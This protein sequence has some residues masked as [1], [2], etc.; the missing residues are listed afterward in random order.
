M[1]TYRARRMAAEDAKTLTG[2][3]NADAIQR[4]ERMP[5]VRLSATSGA[6][7]GAINSLLASAEWCADRPLE[8]IGESAFWRAWIPAGVEAL[9]PAKND[10]VSSLLSRKYMDVSLIPMLHD[11]WTKVRGRPDCDVLFGAAITRL[12]AESVDVGGIAKIQSQYMAS[13]VRVATDPAHNNLSFQIT[14]IPKK[15]EGAIGHMAYLPSEH[16]V[17]PDSEVFRLIKA[18]SGY[19]LAFE[20]QFIDYDSAPGATPTRWLQRAQFVDGGVFDNGPIKLGYELGLVHA[21]QQSLHGISVL[22]IYP[23]QMRHHG[24]L[25][26]AWDAR[27]LRHDRASSDNPANVVRGFDVGRIL[28]TNMIPSARQYQLQTAQSLFAADTMTESARILL[29]QTASQREQVLAAQLKQIATTDSGNRQL[30]QMYLDSL[31]TV[32]TAVRGCTP[33]DSTCIREG[34]AHV[35]ALVGQTRAQMLGLATSTGLQNQQTGAA[36]TLGDTSTIRAKALFSSTRWHPLTGSWFYGFGALL[37]KPF[38]AYDFYVGVYDALTLLVSTSSPCA[39]QP[40]EAQTLCVRDSLLA[41]IQAPPLRLDAADQR[42]LLALYEAEY[43]GSHQRHF[44]ID[45]ASAR[46]ARHDP[47][48]LRVQV[49]TAIV[50]TMRDRMQDTAFADDA[51]RR[52]G[53]TE[54][55]LC[56]SGLRAAANTLSMRLAPVLPVLTDTTCGGTPANTAL[57]LG[58]PAFVNLVTAP[59][60]TIASLTQRFARRFDTQTPNGSSMKLPSMLPSMSM[61]RDERARSGFTL[62]TS[63]PPGPVRVLTVL[64]AEWAWVPQTHAGAGTW[65]TRWDYGQSLAWTY[66]SARMLVHDPLPNRVNDARGSIHWAVGNRVEVKTW[67]TTAFPLVGVQAYHWIGRSDGTHTSFRARTSVGITT[68][69]LANAIRVNVESN[70][71]YLWGTEAHSRWS[72]SIGVNDLP[73]MLYWGSRVVRAL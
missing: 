56:E 17:V 50:A 54:A 52:T 6:S 23:D 7:A 64:P 61:Y 67:H 60:Q 53:T 1:E 73:G 24:T 31:R 8:Q 29:A 10:T 66:L 62:A 45:D 35:D 71:S 4:L 21:N 49:I 18:S 15:N 30:L 32:T 48:E 43:P 34:T 44:T 68:T 70:P 28:V 36:A 63:V 42:I 9:L 51:C 65:G 26:D 2:V 11:R 72:W 39:D 46:S 27:S 25:V 12:F 41:M 13:A 5:A 16:G 40:N 58:D 19:P 3:L 55:L 33:A 57:C 22:Y 47:V 38:R 59:V 69:T 14:R 20:P 37:N